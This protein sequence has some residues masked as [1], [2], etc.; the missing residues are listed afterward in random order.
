MWKNVE[1]TIRGSALLKLYTF[2]SRMVGVAYD[3]VGVDETVVVARQVMARS[4]S[5]KK[6][7]TLCL[8]LKGIS[9]RLSN[10]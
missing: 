10:W 2:A 7:L 5:A 3:D 4:K 1:R 8:D 9:T 6:F